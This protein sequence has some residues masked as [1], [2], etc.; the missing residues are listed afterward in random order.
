MASPIIMKF[1]GTSVRDAEAMRNVAGIVAS[2][3]SR[4]PVVVISAVAE[5]TNTL[6]T[7]GRTAA[8]GDL[9]GARTVSRALHDRHAA[10]ASDLGLQSGDRSGFDSLLTE[11]GG[12]IDR[13]T[14]G[15]AA[16]RECTPRAKDALC[17]CG[18]LLSSRLAAAAM[19]AAGTDAVW[20]DT[21]NFMV[22]DDRYGRARP[23]IDACAPL[24]RGAM[25]PLLDA[26]RVPVTQGFIGVT[27][28][29][30]RTTM[31]RESSDY[32]AAVLGSILEAGT[33]EIWTDVEG[34]LTADP[35]TVESPRL[36]ERLSFG[37]A[38]ELSYFGAKVL[39]P[40]TMIPAEAKGI[41][42][43]I[44]SSLEPRKTG[45]LIGNFPV[46]GQ[47]G[48]RSVAAKQDV[49]LFELKSPP[50]AG[51]Y[52]FREQLYGILM[53]HGVEA[54]IV[55]STEY[56]TSML[57]ARAAIDDTLPADLGKLGGLTVTGDLSVVTL[58]GRNIAGAG[59][60][61]ARLL[62][63]IPQAAGGKIVHGASGRSLNIIVRNE[64]AL[65]TVRRIHAEFFS[66]G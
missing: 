6:E 44:R 5:A 8:S 22:T 23:V 7:I 28:D 46:D 34:V 25:T 47:T 37:E 60:F 64:A 62:K 36:V 65:E 61:Y 53:E 24:T 14:G 27:A 50:G 38:F 32:T 57:V 51:Q 16:L 31:G 63:A 17:A 26:G 30:E 35:R 39:H 18:E 21:K 54:I 41:P 45:T 11:V 20:I 40:S 42:I 55:N 52:I 10:I 56:A 29:G 43:A 19:R 1:G 33:I 3:L 66:A 12:T 9:D 13:L 58:V 2:S 4:R 49:V 15:I 59:D 48:P